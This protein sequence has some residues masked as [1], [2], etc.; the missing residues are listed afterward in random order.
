MDLQLQVEA[1]GVRALQATHLV[2]L[3]VDGLQTGLTTSWQVVKPQSFI[4]GV[5]RITDKL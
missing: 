3:A 4:T 5:D 1:I 2:K